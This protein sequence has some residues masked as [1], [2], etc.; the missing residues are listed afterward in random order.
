MMIHP[1]TPIQFSKVRYC[2]RT[3]MKIETRTEVNIDRVPVVTEHIIM[4]ADNVRSMR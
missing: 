3:G 1:D 2:A 4:S